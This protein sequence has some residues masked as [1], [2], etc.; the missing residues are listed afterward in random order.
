MARIGSVMA[1][2]STTNATSWTFTFT[3]GVQ[4]GHWLI[5]SIALDAAGGTLPV[6]SVTDTQGNTWT[7]DPAL[8][9]V[10]GVTVSTHLIYARVDNALTTSDTLTFTSDVFRSR[11]AISIEAFD[12]VLQAA[13]RD[14]VATGT[15]VSANLTVGATPATTHSRELVVA[16]F[17]FGPDRVFTAGAGYTS[18]GAVNSATGAGN[19]GTA[20]EWKYVTATGAQTA[21]GTLDS[22]STYSAVIATF[23]IND[24]AKSDAL[25]I[26]WNND[27]D[28]SDTGENVTT[29]LRE[30]GVAI[31]YGRDQ[32]RSLAPM[33]PGQ[34]SFELDNESRDYTPDNT[35]SPLYGNLMPG[36][37]LRYQSTHA[38][39][40]Y[41]LYLGYGDEYDVQ[42][43]RDDISS[44]PMTG[45]DGLSRMRGVKLSTAVYQSIRVGAAIEVILDAIGW[46]A[47]DRDIDLGGSVLPWWWEEGTDAFTAL[48]DLL[49]SEGPPA[50]ATIGADGTFV[51]RDRH[52]RLIR[53]AS[54]NVQATFRDT[55]AEPT[56]SHLAYDVGWR[57]IV[58]QVTFSVDEHAA[59]PA[60][61]D[62]WTT[63][64]TVRV[65]AGETQTITATFTDPCIDLEADYTVNAGG[66]AKV[67]L[68]RTSGETAEIRVSGVTAATVRNLKVQG[69]PV[70]IAQTVQVQ[71]SD[72]TSIANHGARSYPDSAAKWANR[73]DAEAIADLILNQRANRL[74]VVTITL[75]AGADGDDTRLHQMLSRDLSD[76]I[77]IV[78]AETGINAAFFIEQIQHDISQAG[79]YHVT[80]FACEKI[81]DQAGNVFRFD[82]AG[83]GFDDGVF[84]SDGLIDHTKI[85]ILGHATQGQLDQEVLAY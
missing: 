83:A 57:D 15:G 20:N 5:G 67:T 45:L 34:M 9:V 71:R 42:P 55:G 30:R 75:T 62:V 82:V 49:G 53:Q 2:G 35:S 25:A 18:S 10:S 85:L 81:R 73:F 59:A 41:T 44:A 47:S 4:T 79:L 3:A 64:E 66:A 24:V 68:S 32:A 19:R 31:Q 58:N 70:T 60:L 33:Q 69:R 22:S 8:S 65:A 78:D 28:F 21:T 40:T 1:A 54:R 63:T 6:L 80:R 38:G 13:P 43:G 29:R 14:Q 39:T 37:P 23:W 84:G 48:Q 12:D 16:A 11:I 51:F 7:A 52:H 61:E 74:P 17:G 46:P 76:R 56:F 26:D 72:D 27:G 36:R 50:F 77:T